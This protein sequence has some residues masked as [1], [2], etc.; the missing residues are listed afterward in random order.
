[1]SRAEIKP[2]QT[3]IDRAKMTTKDGISK[4]RFTVVFLDGSRVRKTVQ[5]PK[6]VSESALRDM[7]REK[8]E[9]W[10][11]LENS[12]GEWKP[13]QPISEFI[14]AVS[15][16]EIENSNR[17]KQRSKDRYKISARHLEKALR[18]YPINKAITFRVLEK[19]L[20][21]IALEHGVGTATSCRSVLSKY[22][23]RPLK[24]AGLI[25]ANP[26]AGEELNLPQKLDA[27]GKGKTIHTL[28]EAEW[29]TVI[30]HLLHRDTDKALHAKAINVRQVTKAKHARLVRMTL[31]QAT[32]GLRISE[33]NAIKWQDVQDTTEGVL[34]IDATKVKGRL[35]RERGRTIPVLHEGV[36]AYLREHRGM[37]EEFVIGSPADTYKQW[38]S[39]NAD[40]DVPELYRQV[41]KA[42]NVPILA[43]MRSHDWRATLNGIYEP[44]FTPEQRAA[45][46]GHTIAVNNTY[47]TDGLNIEQKALNVKDAL[48]KNA[49]N[50]AQQHSS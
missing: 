41:A 27:Q 15:I 34:F 50:T 18:G 5:A 1:M 30:E 39:N 10:F 19:T 8:V 14:T 17:I 6:G 48:N 21:S 29:R 31:L 22:V 24:R 44:Y 7:A 20:E 43:H 3:T 38:D 47:Y 2:G 32:T 33:A 37:N 35:G 4:L 13:S 28:N 25:D 36:A 12:T 40:D 42:T 16:P 49:R 11:R 46:F 45:M 9:E 26:I 23:I